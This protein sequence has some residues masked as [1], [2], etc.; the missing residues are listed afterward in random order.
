MIIVKITQLDA[1]QVTEGFYNLQLLFV[2]NRQSK[3]GTNIHPSH[4]T[5]QHNP[6]KYAHLTEIGLNRA[7]CWDTRRKPVT[8]SSQLAGY[9]F[10]RSW[11]QARYKHAQTT[12]PEHKLSNLLLLKSPFYFYLKGSIL[13]LNQD[14]NR[15]SFYYFK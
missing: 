11:S 14:R 8:G 2:T 3:M 9:G 10:P 13:L 15:F 12:N 1:G 7:L 5:T 6:K 4:S